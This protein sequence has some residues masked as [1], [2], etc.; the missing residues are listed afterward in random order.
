MGEPAEIADDTGQCGGDDALIDGAEPQHDHQADEH[1]ADFALGRLVARR[2]RAPD[3]PHHRPISL[4]GPIAL[5]IARRALGDSLAS[6]C[7]NQ[8]V[9][10][11]F[12]ALI[13]LWPFSVAT[14]PTRRRSSG[15]GALR[16]TS[17]A[18]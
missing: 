17:P 14:R 6:F 13:R 1:G 3:L 8:S 7:A 5:R 10:R 15:S 4:S 16:D 18:S 12:I 2:W 11:R 9:R